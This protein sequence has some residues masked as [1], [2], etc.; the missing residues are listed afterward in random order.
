MGSFDKWAHRKIKNSQK[1]KA[2]AEKAKTE[3][4]V[5]RQLQGY[6]PNTKK[7]NGYPFDNDG[8]PIF[9]EPTGYAVGEGPIKE[10]S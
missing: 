5:S 2:K 8:N 3:K 1:A 4:P 7:I 9:P 6:M 10:N